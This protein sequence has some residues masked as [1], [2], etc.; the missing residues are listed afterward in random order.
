MSGTK[1]VFLT[2]GD[3]VPAAMA[4]RLVRLLEELERELPDILLEIAHFARDDQHA[5]SEAGRYPL[6]L[7][8]LIA[9]DGGLRK[10]PRSVIIAATV[11]TDNGVRLLSPFCHR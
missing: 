10:N 4:Q 1:M 2:N 11:I 3:I 7:Q 8:D 5:I 9:D 6:T